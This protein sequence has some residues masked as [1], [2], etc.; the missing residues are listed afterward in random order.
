MFPAN[1]K[2][3]PSNHFPEIL[4]LQH[5]INTITT[6]DGGPISTSIRRIEVNMAN[7]SLKVEQPLLQRSSEMAK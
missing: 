6:S 1:T 3:T 4:H 5:F 7:E 2:T